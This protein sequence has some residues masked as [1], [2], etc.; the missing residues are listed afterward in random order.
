MQIKL[1][2]PLGPDDTIPKIDLKVTDVQKEKLPRLLIR[3]EAQEDLFL[4]SVKQMYS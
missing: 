1:I 3:T 4:S 2:N